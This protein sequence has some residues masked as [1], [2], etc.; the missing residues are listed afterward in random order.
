M[1]Q[2][3]LSCYID[4]VLLP[5]ITSC[6]TC[7]V[8]KNKLGNCAYVN[9]ITICGGQEKILHWQK[10]EAIRCVLSPRSTC[11]QYP[12][13]TST[14]TLLFW[15]LATFGRVALPY[16]NRRLLFASA[17][18][19]GAAIQPHWLQAG[20]YVIL[21]GPQAPTTIITS[22]WW[23]KEIYDHMQAGGVEINNGRQQFSDAT[24]I[25]PG[26]S[27]KTDLVKNNQ[28]ESN[29]SMRFLFLS[30]PVIWI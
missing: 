24:S 27:P 16:T 14:M 3:Y 25:K 20:H 21:F 13:M 12:T 8:I 17:A 26:D 11:A 29:K 1:K 15:S 6:I 9:G 22:S 10:L 23:G 18:W 7:H 28:N 5:L 19:V 4:L 2:L 30:R